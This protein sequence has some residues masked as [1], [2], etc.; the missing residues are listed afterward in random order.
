MKSNFSSM[1]GEYEFGIYYFTRGIN[2]IN[3]L[4]MEKKIVKDMISLF[5]AMNNKEELDKKI[6]KLKE[7]YNINDEN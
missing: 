1:F 6:N 4:N 7:D 2:I 3:G 5:K